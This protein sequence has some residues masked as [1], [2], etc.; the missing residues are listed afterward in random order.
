MSCRKSLFFERFDSWEINPIMKGLSSLI[1]NER[2]CLSIGWS[3]PGVLVYILQL[4]ATYATKLCQNSANKV[5]RV[6]R[7]TLFPTRFVHLEDARMISSSTQIKRPISIKVACVKHSKIGA[8]TMFHSLRC[9]LHP[10]TL[11][12][13]LCKREV[14]AKF[15]SRFFLQHQGYWI[16]FYRY[17]KLRVRARMLISSI[18]QISNTIF[19]LL[20]ITRVTNTLNLFYKTHSKITSCATRSR[21]KFPT[22]S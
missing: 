12:D 15:R 22:F 16:G 5:W 21:W 8:W 9:I 3:T 11:V 18:N 17:F 20:F 1:R 4:I 13:L 10:R 14:I 2:H 7:Q 19:H 6:C